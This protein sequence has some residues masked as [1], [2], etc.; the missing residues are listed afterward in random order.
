MK[1]LRIMK[2]IKTHL[3]YTKVG[4][5]MGLLALL[6]SCEGF[7][8]TGVPRSMVATSSVFENDKTAEQAMVGLYS[9]MAF[10]S[11]NTLNGRF[12]IACALYADDLEGVNNGWYFSGVG[13]APFY[14]NALAGEPK[15]TILL[16][17]WNSFYSYI[18]QANSIIENLEDNES[19]TSSLKTKLVGEAKFIRAFSHFY[20]VNLF[21]DVPLIT[22]TSVDVTALAPRTASDNVYEQILTDLQDAA[23]ALE[24]DE[25][26]TQVNLQAVEALLARV[27]L[28][29]ENWTDAAD[30]ASSAIN[31]ETLQDLNQV[32][33]AYAHDVIFELNTSSKDTYGVADDAY[34]LVP[35]Y[36]APS[37]AVTESLFDSFEAQDLRLANWIK[38]Y[39]ETENFYPYKYT[40]Q[41]YYDATADSQEFPVILRLAEQFL[42]R[43]E[44]NTQLGETGAAISDLNEVRNR[45]GLADYSGGTSKAEVLDAI[46]TERRHEFFCE[47]G[48]RWFDLKRTGRADEVL[49]AVK[50]SWSS[51]AIDFILPE[52]ATNNNPNLK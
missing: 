21:G 34:Q 49:S 12:N 31:G 32:F 41:Y 3:L 11:N 14:N 48:H 45:A 40:L 4:F 27:Y 50:P 22:T 8:D 26:K 51:D 13:Y 9:S 44:A 43:A 38:Q 20:L 6:N 37:F 30:Y 10:G 15:N 47:M 42:I 46:A 7:L 25:D 1:R 18:Y 2:N 29:R 17:M 36:S 5:F 35:L 33:K 28:Y 24:Y 52:A 19:V 23:D 16:G 39:K